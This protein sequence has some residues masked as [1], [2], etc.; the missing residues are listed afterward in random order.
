MNHRKR[1]EEK[2]LKCP[3]CPMMFSVKADLLVH[4]KYHRNAWPWRCGACNMFFKTARGLQNHFA[5][6]HGDKIN[7]VEMLSNLVNKT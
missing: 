3:S 7:K 4:V 5:I 2:T 6:S 1:H